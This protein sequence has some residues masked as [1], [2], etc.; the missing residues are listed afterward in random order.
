MD[1]LKN[2]V[3]WEFGKNIAELIRHPM[4]IKYITKVIDLST[5]FFEKYDIN[6]IINKLV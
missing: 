1:S 2:T 5:Q 4:D 3:F 6:Q